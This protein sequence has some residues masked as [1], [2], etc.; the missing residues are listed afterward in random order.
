MRTYENTFIQFQLKQKVKN[1]QDKNWQHY[2]H[3]ARLKITHAPART[4]LRKCRKIGNIA[5][6]SFSIFWR[7]AINVFLFSLFNT[8]F[9]LQLSINKIEKVPENWQ[10]CHGFIFSFLPKKNIFSCFFLTRCELHRLEKKDLNGK[11]ATPLSKS[12]D[13]R[14]S[15]YN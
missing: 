7:K 11:L 12:T 5:M 2:C 8:Q 6:D 1:I 3:I 4:K 9:H 13:K 15:H 14:N 10:H